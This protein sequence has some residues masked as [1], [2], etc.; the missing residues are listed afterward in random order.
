MGLT[1]LSIIVLSYNT[2]DLLRKCLSSIQV[3]LEDYSQ[4]FKVSNYEVVVV[5]N[6]SSDG[7]VDMVNKEFPSIVL[8]RNSTNK[9][10]AKAINQAAAVC[11]GEF[12]L[13]SN[14][15]VIYTPGS[16]ARMVHYAMTHPTAGIV[17]PQLIYPNGS[18][19]RSYGEVPSVGVAFRNLFFITSFQ[20]AIRKIMWPKIKIDSRPKRVGYVDG[21]AMLIRR[22]VWDKVQGFDERFFFYAEDA[23]ICYRVRRL[24]FDVVFLPY[25]QVIHL[26]GGGSSNIEPSKL[27]CLKLE[28]D[29]K[30][31]EKYWGSRYAR[32]YLLLTRLYA[33]ERMQLER[34]FSLRQNNHAKETSRQKFE[35]FRSIYR[36]CSSMLKSK[37]L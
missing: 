33:W 13:V 31:V 9:G 4:Q 34:F 17:G 7:S 21:A 23:D 29:Y 1:K 18:W 36:E 3:G 30:L 37:I 26:R 32:Y 2:Q 5:D 28:S 27:M 19:Q 12:I 25:A 11:R 15:D 20:H 14:S 8:L 16:I 24:G 6:A 35:I 10:F 22:E